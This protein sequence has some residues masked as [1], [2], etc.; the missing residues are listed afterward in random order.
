MSPTLA[1]RAGEA[2]AAFDPE[3]DRFVAESEP[4]TLGHLVN[5]AFAIE[6]AL[7]DPLPHQRITVYQHFLPLAYLFRGNTA[8]APLKHE[9][10]RGLGD[11]PRRL[12]RLHRLGSIE[13]QHENHSPGE[14]AM[15]SVLLL[16]AAYRSAASGRP[17]AVWRPLLAASNTPADPG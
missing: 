17:E 12:P 1:E 7:I 16:D 2:P 13:A 6:P 3:I 4:L 8:A 10:R 5:P 11:H 15:R 9:L 14:A